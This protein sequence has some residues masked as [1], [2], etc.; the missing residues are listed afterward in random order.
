MSKGYIRA[1]SSVLG[2]L[3]VTLFVLWVV[4]L[5]LDASAFNKCRTMG[6]Q[7][8]IA[9]RMERF[10]IDDGAIVPYHEY[11]EARIAWDR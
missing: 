9:Y 11:V 10:C 6:A 7:S 4:G 3:V 1:A 5:V 8:G 2:V